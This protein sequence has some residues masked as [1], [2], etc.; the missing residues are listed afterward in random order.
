MKNIR[1][2][3]AV[4]SA[5]ILVNAAQAQTLSTD[6]SAAVAAP[7][8]TG[9]ANAPYSTDPFVQKRQADSIA[10][11]EYKARKKAAKKQMKAEKK[12]AKAELKTEKAESTEIRN[13]TL[14]TEPA[15][16]AEPAIFYSQPAANTRFTQQ[17]GTAASEPPCT[18][19]DFE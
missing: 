15:V 13:S 2:L 4:A 14:A 9:N 1:T 11:K 3:L 16:K 7:A 18:N 17:P 10:K 8:A 19:K 12:E 5:L 6:A